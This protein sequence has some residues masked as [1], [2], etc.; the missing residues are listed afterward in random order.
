MYCVMHGKLHPVWPGT[1]LQAFRPT[2]RGGLLGRIATILLFLSQ[3]HNPCAQLTDILM[4]VLMNRW[5]SSG[6]TPLIAR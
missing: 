6:L 4:R 3:K 5:L 2:V 1:D